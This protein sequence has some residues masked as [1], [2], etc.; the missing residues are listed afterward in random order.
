MNLASKKTDADVK[1]HDLEVHCK[2][3]ADQVKEFANQ[4]FKLGTE[5]RALQEEIGKADVRLPEIQNLKNA[6]AAAKV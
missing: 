1:Y 4:I 6:A 2:K 5:I 3:Q